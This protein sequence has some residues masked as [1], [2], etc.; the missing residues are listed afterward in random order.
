MNFGNIDKFLVEVK[1]YKKA[2]YSDKQIV[3][4]FGE[5]YERQEISWDDYETVAYVL[6][7]R[8]EKQ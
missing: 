6:G 2:G 3:D 4:A 8:L 7:Y 1:K 5:K